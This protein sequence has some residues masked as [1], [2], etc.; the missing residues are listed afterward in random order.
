ME[1]ENVIEAM[2]S[3]SEK[4]VNLEKSNQKILKYI[5]EKCEEA[6]TTKKKAASSIGCDQQTITTLLNEG[7][8]INYGRG[9]LYLFHK[10]ELLD[11]REVRIEKD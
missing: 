9:D 5:L 11:I 6:V 10:S 8:I 3:M 4:I 2:A 1:T 7:R